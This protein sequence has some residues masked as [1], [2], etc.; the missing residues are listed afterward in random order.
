MATH[1]YYACVMFENVIKDLLA[2]GMTEAEIA[3]RVGKSVP[4]INRIRNGKQIPL[5]PLGDALVKLR[6]E[7]C[8][9]RAAA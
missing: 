3:N 4:T 9:D 8:P 2:A 5:Y 7:I 1:A 6:A